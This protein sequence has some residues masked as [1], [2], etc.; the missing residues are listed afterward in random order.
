VNAV[1]AVQLV[2]SSRPFTLIA[3]SGWVATGLLHLVIGALAIAVALGDRR[4]KPDEV[5]A[6]EAI[7]SAPLGGVL[8][9]AVIVGLVGLG[10]WTLADALLNRGPRNRWSSAVSSAAQ[11]VVYLGL[12][13][14]PI[15]LL[16]GG[17]LES[18]RT[19]RTVSTFLL[20]SVAGAVVLILI[21][22]AIAAAGVYFIVKGIRRRFSWELRPMTRRRG[23]AVR[24]LGAVGYVARGIAFLLL[25]GLIIVE[26]LEF[27]PNQ[28]TGLAGAFAAVE[29]GF[30]GPI[31][32]T[33]IG[34]GLMIYGVYSVARAR[35]SQI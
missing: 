21:G 2:H 4:A 23:R 26:S 3:R 16:L 11:G 17:E 24:L 8:L 14:P 15:I 34:A 6:F 5:G 13:V 32:L 29:R 20:D 19:A 28:V 27:D 35:L 22:V 31:W 18:G 33:V 12:A 9:A 10:V 7:A 25:A 30:L 1:D